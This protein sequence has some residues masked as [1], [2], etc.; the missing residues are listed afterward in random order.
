MEKSSLNVEKF[1]AM[2]WYSWSIEHWGKWNACHNTM[3]L[4]TVLVKLCL[5][6]LG[7]CSRS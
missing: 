4:K 3:T 5:I 7:Q 6:R 1:G 2:D